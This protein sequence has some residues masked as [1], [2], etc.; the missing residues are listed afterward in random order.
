VW[1]LE[2]ITVEKFAAENT[3]GINI[4]LK[5]KCSSVPL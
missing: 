1:Q 4:S 2:F 3:K 5:E